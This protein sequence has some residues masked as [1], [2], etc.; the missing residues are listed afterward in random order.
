MAVFHH[1][2]DSI[3][4]KALFICKM[5]KGFAIIHTYPSAPGAEVPGA[6]PEI[7]M[8]VFQNGTDDIIT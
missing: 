1:G 6:E 3:I 5:R 4:I 2:T 7:A 8:T